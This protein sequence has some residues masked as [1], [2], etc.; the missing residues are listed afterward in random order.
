MTRIIIIG[1][2]AAGMMT[3]AALAERNVKAEIVLIERNQRLGQ[4]VIISGGGRCNVTTGVED[5]KEVLS[6][7]PRGARFLRNAMHGFPPRAMID[8]V[9]AHGVPLK[10]EEDLRIFPKSD[11]GTH[12]VG[13]FENMLKKSKVKVICKSVVT[14]LSHNDKFHVQ[15]NTNEIISGDVLVLTTGGQAYKGTGSKGDGYSFAET[16]GHKITDLAPSLTAFTLEDKWIKELAGLSFEKVKLKFTAEKTYEFTGP[17]MFTHK[18]VTGPAVFALSALSAFERF[19]REKPARL[20]L[21]FFPD[22]NQEEFAQTVKQ[23]IAGSPKKQFH[24]ILGHLLP[25]SFAKQI[26]VYLDIPF[27]KRNNELS[28]K[29]INKTIQSLKQL[30]LNIIGRSPGEEFVTAGG[31]DL[32]EVDPKT[33]Q[34]K[35]TPGL[36]FAGEILNIDGFTGGYNLQAAWAGGRLVG[37]SIT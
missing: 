17:F 7:Y 18:G 6:A 26:C 2:G 35:I 15:L 1:G 5:L 8:W 30:P 9:E 29:D 25:N 11:N 34:S 21:D 28:K 20:E 32:S 37:E 27:H 36:Y 33:M 22:M 23:L 12:I 16:L 31:V 14:G 19:F 4:K 10:K 24:N 13:I 3:A